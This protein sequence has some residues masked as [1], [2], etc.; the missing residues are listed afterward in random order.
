MRLL[1]WDFDGT[2]GYRI[3]GM[4]SGALLELLQQEMPDLQATADQLQPHL[5][6]GFPWQRSDQPHPEIQTPE[7]WWN[8][9]APVFEDAFQ[10][11]GIEISQSTSLAQQVRQTYT[12]PG[13]W[14]L[15]D[16]ALP[17]LDQ[18]STQSWT[19]VLLSNHV[20][21]LRE[22]IHHLGLEPR[23]ARIFNSAETGYEKPHPHAFQMVLDAFPES[24]TVWMIGDSMEADVLGAQ[25]LGIPAILARGRDKDARYDCARISDVKALVTREHKQRRRPDHPHRNR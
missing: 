24:T 3:G 19:H 8:R 18:L 21:E 12:N 16:D 13:R 14:R 15:F 9:L 6:A 7:E 5:Q 20:P 11:L 2:L 10:G 22:I 23:L 4:W 25:A 1:I 17:T